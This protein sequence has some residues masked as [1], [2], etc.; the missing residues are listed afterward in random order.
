VVPGV[1]DRGGPGGGA[2]HRGP[3]AGQHCAERRGGAGGP[4]R[5]EREKE[6]GRGAARGGYGVLHVYTDAALLRRGR[7]IAVARGC[8]TRENEG[9][10]CRAQETVF[11]RP[12]ATETYLLLNAQGFRL[13]L[14]SCRDVS[15]LTRIRLR[16]LALHDLEHPAESV[17]RQLLTI[18]D[19]SGQ[20]DLWSCEISGLEPRHSGYAKRRANV[21]LAIDVANCSVQ[22]NPNTLLRWQ[23]WIAELLD[24]IM[25]APLEEAG[26]VRLAPAALPPAEMDPAR[27][28]KRAAD[29]LQAMKTR[30][31]TVMLL[32][33][34][35]SHGVVIAM[36]KGHRA[37]CEVRVETTFGEVRSATAP[38]WAPALTR[39]A[40]A[41]DRVS[42]LQL[43]CGSAAGRGAASVRVGGRVH[44]HPGAARSIA[45]R[46]H[47]RGPVGL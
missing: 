5:G 25:P 17:Q 41:G 35:R 29:S 43:R 37:L 15:W 18:N 9:S 45:A 14:R 42:E 2:G 6:G 11:P 26:E 16:R 4:G 7:R 19:E 28:R 36:N 31:R 39:P 46:R 13:G 24:V 23:S 47:A 21:E 20:K 34:F 32:I 8:G 22:W 38:R 10:R 40:A 3:G 27:Q 44:A 30:Q 12:A 33:S 1:K